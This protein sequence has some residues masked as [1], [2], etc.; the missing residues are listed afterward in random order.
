M[1]PPEVIFRQAPTPAVVCE[2]PCIFKHAHHPILAC[3]PTVSFAPLAPVPA[4]VASVPV[5]TMA[6]PALTASYMPVQMASIAVQPAAVSMLA[7]Q[8]AAVATSAV[9]ASVAMVPSASV[10]AIPSAPAVS[11][12]S[13]ASAPAP[14]S[15]VAAVP[16][17]SAAATPTIGLVM[18][19]AAP[20]T[21]SAAE[22][23]ASEADL[24][25]AVAVLTRVRDN[26]VTQQ[27]AAAASRA[28]AA[29]GQPGAATA[30]SE[31][32]QLSKR[33]DELNAKLEGLDRRLKAILDNLK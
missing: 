27:A 31:Y 14:T 17:Q 9:P 20:R 5:Q 13:V 33:V 24:Q 6:A 23:A 19:A 18:G 22:S 12:A 1:S 3:Q 16:F 30:S 32:Q 10:A 29:G 25:T 21:S 8:Q 2:K 4:M 7:V 15:Y 28:A 11:F 26:M